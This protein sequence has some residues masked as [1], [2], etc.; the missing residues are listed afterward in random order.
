M[1]NKIRLIGI[2]ALMALIGFSFAA[3]DDDGGSGPGGGGSSGGTGSVTIYIRNA[4]EYPITLIE[5]FDVTNSIPPPNNSKR[6]SSGSINVQSGQTWGPQKVTGIPLDTTGSLF[7]YWGVSVTIN[8]SNS[9]GLQ[10]PFAGLKN[11]DTIRLKFDSWDGG[12][13]ISYDD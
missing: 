9:K 8:T 13:I 2:I 10:R 11:G 1:K 12:G 6:Y 4:G 5:V 3:C 7:G